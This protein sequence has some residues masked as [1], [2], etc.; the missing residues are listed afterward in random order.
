ME[1]A[2]LLE[3]LFIVLRKLAIFKMVRKVL[4]CFSGEIVSN[5]GQR[6]LMKRLK[7]DGT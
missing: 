6:F 5:S 7:K 3:R 1:F 4:F 2:K